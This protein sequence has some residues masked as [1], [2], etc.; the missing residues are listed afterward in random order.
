MWLSWSCALLPLMNSLLMINYQDLL[1]VKRINKF[2]VHQCQAQKTF[3]FD[4][5]RSVTWPSPDYQELK[6]VPELDKKHAYR[7]SQGQAQ[8][9]WIWILVHRLWTGYDSGLPTWLISI[10]K[11][12]KSVFDNIL[13]KHGGLPHV[14]RGPRRFD[15]LNL[16]WVTKLK[17]YF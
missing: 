14:L 10:T 15:N 2:W 12:L 9:F 17:K 6:K 4:L 1:L 7:V 8:E 13:I 11:T 3:A 5:H 16:V